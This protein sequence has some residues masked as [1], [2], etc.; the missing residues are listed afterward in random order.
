MLIIR[1]QITDISDKE[2]NHCIYTAFDYGEVSN[3]RRTE[4]QNLKVP[5]LGLQLSLRN[6][7]KPGVKPRMKM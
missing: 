4:S 5:R 3:I 6:I 7:L 1:P 2:T